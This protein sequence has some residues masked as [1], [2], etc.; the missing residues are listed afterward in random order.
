MRTLSLYSR[1]STRAEAS[2]LSLTAGYDATQH[3]L[4]ACTT[5][6]CFLSSCL[7]PVSCGRPFIWGR[8][9]LRLW[10]V[11]DTKPANDT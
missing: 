4:Q 6:R 3:T 11:K 9:C 8:F 10:S 1:P 2:S 5:S 7:R